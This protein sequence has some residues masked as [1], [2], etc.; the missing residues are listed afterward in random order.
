M[1]TLVGMSYSPW[2]QK[3]RWALDHHRVSYRFE[4]HTPLLGEPALRVRARMLGGVVS[5]PILVGGGERQLDSFAI[6]RRA[7]ELAEGTHPLFPRG[8][9]REV[10]LWNARS[11]RFLSAGRVRFYTRFAASDAALLEAVPTYVPGALRGVMKPGTGLAIAYL[12]RKYARAASGDL[13]AQQRAELGALRSALAASGGEYLLGDF[14]YADI[15]M[16]VAFAMVEPVG[17]PHDGLGPARREVWRDPELTSE[18]RDLLAWR[19]RIY[20]RWR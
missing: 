3:A 18:N 7:E 4:E 15:A 6:A 8:R 5:V 17:A 12:K 9:E 20:A 10:E 13:L 2:T 19:D 11:D 16:A 1:R 14:S